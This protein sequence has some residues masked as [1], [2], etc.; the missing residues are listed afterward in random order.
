MERWSDLRE[1]LVGTLAAAVL[2]GFF[3]AW[4]LLDKM[5]L[6]PWLEEDTL[7]ESLTSALYATAGV[8]FVLIARRSLFLQTKSAGPRYV[9]LI[10]W[11]LLMVLFAG[12]EI[13]WGQRIFGTE[14]PEWLSE[15]NVQDET[16]VHNIG[17]VDTFMGGYHRW[18]SIFMLLNGLVIPVF[19]ETNYGRRVIQWWGFPV[20]P[21][22]LWL[23]FVG[24]YFY[25][26]IMRDYT[27]RTNDAAEVR[28]FLLSVA[29]ASF[30]LY[31]AWRPWTVFRSDER[32]ARA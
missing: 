10:M 24:A 3:V 1:I 9:W 19:A 6:Y 7:I 15:I 31:G 11:A 21:V 23:F 26:V 29:L 20:V 5:S 22:P 27:Y 16:N 14:T 12:E 32:T 30:A 18:L 4:A 28:E 13:S 8:G 17:W 25:G 2:I